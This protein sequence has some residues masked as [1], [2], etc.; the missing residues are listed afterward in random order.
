MAPLLELPAT[1]VQVTG[2]ETATASPVRPPSPPVP[3]AVDCPWAPQA[4]T[5]TLLTPGGIVTVAVSATTTTTR[6]APVVYVVVPGG[7]GAVMQSVGAAAD[8]GAAT[9][10]RV[11]ATTATTAATTVIRGATDELQP[12]PRRLCA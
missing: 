12:F 1:T 2:D 8:A 7:S 6:T 11:P 9:A 3:A 5:C 4:S 10:T